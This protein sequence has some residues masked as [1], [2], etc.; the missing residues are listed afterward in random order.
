MKCFFFTQ[1]IARDF[2][3]VVK[4]FL[5]LSMTCLFRGVHDRNHKVLRETIRPQ[6]L[7]IPKQ[8]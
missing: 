8:I 5:C 6:R 3:K 7:V 4:K 1:L 2:V